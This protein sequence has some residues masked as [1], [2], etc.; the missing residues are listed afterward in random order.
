[1]MHISLWYIVGYVMMMFLIIFF[2]FV[3]LR[4]NGYGYKGYRGRKKND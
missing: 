2:G 4:M 3:Y 1:M